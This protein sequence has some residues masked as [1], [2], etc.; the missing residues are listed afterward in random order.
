MRLRSLE[1]KD[2]ELMLEWMHDDTVVH[3]LQTNFVDKTIHDCQKF[4]DNSTKSDNDI[5]MAVVDDNDVYMGTVSLKN[6][7]SENAEFAITIRACA[8]GKGYSRY[9]MERII[10]KGFDELNLKE[11]YWCVSPENKRA[12]NFYEKSEFT[13][14]DPLTINASL[15][16]SSEQISKYI[17]YMISYEEYR[18]RFKSDSLRK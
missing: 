2:A 17:W 10:E 6:I 7:N 12:V 13:C 5:H 3:Y 8:M 15:E 11:I 4:I 1:L 18:K 16:Y 9:S 14:V